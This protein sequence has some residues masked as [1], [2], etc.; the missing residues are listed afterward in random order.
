MMDDALWLL[1]L[2]AAASD[3]DESVCKTLRFSADYISWIKLY[4]YKF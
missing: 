1:I 2:L 4:E 3:D